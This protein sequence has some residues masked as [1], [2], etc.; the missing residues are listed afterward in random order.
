MTF[1]KIFE[2]WPTNFKLNFLSS[3]AAK[4]QN[5]SVYHMQNFLNFPK[6][7]LLFIIALFF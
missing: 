7:V 4:M 5:F 2:I 3:Q 1:F 6:M